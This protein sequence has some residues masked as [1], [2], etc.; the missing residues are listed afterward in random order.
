MKI[1]C[2]EEHIL[3]DKKLHRYTDPSI[4]I[5]LFRRGQHSPCEDPNISALAHNTLGFPY[6][7]SLPLDKDASFEVIYVSY[8]LH[9]CPGRILV[10]KYFLRLTYSDRAIISLTNG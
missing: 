7:A 6:G 4:S 10:D 2:G 9:P 5:S 3:D 1:V 8:N